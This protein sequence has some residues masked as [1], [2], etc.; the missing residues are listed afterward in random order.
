MS[1]NYKKNKNDASLGGKKS[2]LEISNGNI[3]TIT[4]MEQ[5]ALTGGTKNINKDA[6]NNGISTVVP[7]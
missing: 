6:F 3:V 5:Q 7:C 4:D 1:F 2:L